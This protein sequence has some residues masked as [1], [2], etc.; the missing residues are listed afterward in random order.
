ME[1]TGRRIHLSDLTDQ[2]KQ[3]AREVWLLIEQD[4][5]VVSTALFRELFDRHPHVKEYFASTFVNGNWNTPAFKNHMINVLM[6]TLRQVLW[7][8]DSTDKVTAILKD[9][10][11][12]HKQM[13]KGIAPADT[14]ALRTVFMFVL[15]DYLGNT[16]TD[17]HLAAMDKVLRAAFCI[18]NDQL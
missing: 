8:M 13:K 5:F 12:K 14:D 18:F 11:K 9:L 17:E 4:Y 3:S 2:D 6:P 1:T 15:K 10:G 16:A 7:M